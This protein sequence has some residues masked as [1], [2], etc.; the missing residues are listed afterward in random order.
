MNQHDPI[1]GR[2]VYVQ[3]E[4]KTYRTYY[5]ENGEGIPLVCLHTAGADARE[6]RHQLCDPDITQN[7]RVIA[8]DLPWHGKSIPPSDFYLMEEEYKLTTR[9]YC[10]FIVAFCRALDLRKPVI[11]GQSMGG[12]VCLWLAL[13]HESEFSALIA[14]EGCEYSP[15]WWID[16]LHHP[17]IHGGDAISTCMLGL[18]SPE[19]P[20]EYVNETAWYYAQG[21]PGVFKGDLYFYSVNSDIRE[22]IHKI[23]GKVPI[24]FLTGD[25]DFACTPEM[26]E[27]T[28][29]KVKNS[30][31][32]IFSGGH[33]P[34]SE[35]P[36]KFKGVVTP[37]L[38]KVIAAD[39]ERRGQ[40]SALGRGEN[41][42]ELRSAGRGE[43]PAE[44]RRVIDL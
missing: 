14:L 9:F 2:Y 7:F 33:F 3:C 39:P 25:Y 18:M 15:G 30:E 42:T 11:M 8:F 29:E 41:P 5:E 40:S 10:E 28:A 27:R 31:C 20:P 6:Y 34:T 23:S 36:D 43:R 26:T 19:S 22:H 1:V 4:G 44:G 13:K 12:N 35:D 38:K 21:G 24:Y 16:P 32:V 17:Q 37:V